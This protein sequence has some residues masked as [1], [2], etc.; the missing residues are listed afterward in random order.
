M[1]DAPPGDVQEEVES[2]REASPAQSHQS[3]VAGLSLAP[4]LAAFGDRSARE[5]RQG[6][7]ALDSIW[8]RGI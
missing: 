6:P 2:V 7:S 1:R 4:I 8:K 5:E 3:P